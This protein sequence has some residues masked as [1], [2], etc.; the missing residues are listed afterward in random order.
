MPFEFNNQIVNGFNIPFKE[1]ISKDSGS[2][3][4]KTCSGYYRT[5]YMVLTNQELYF[6]EKKDASEYYKM[7]VLTPGV[8][9]SMKRYVT[10]NFIMKQKVNKGG[11]NHHHHHHHH[12]HGSNKKQYKVFPIEIIVGGSQSNIGIQ[13]AFN[14]HGNNNGIITIFFDSLDI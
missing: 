11:H 13:E 1:H 14:Q 6:Y 9:I 10:T 7:I 4:I 3:M 8:F 2:F 5:Q 12:H